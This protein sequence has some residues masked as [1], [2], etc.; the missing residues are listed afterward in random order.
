MT[1]VTCISTAKILFR[2]TN[3]T[4]L[5]LFCVNYTHTHDFSSLYFIS[6]KKCCMLHEYCTSWLEWLSWLLVCVSILNSFPFPVSSSLLSSV[7]WCLAHAFTLHIQA[8][9]RIILQLCFWGRT[10]NSYV[11]LPGRFFFLALSKFECFLFRTRPLASVWPLPPFLASYYNI[12]PYHLVCF[13]QTKHH[14][15]S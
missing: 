12:Q 3:H 10:T 2:Q 8:K 5:C 13:A 11:E 7:H 14:H 15:C 4:F 6:K 1:C 9:I